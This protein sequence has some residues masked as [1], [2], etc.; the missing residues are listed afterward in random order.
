MSSDPR[1]IVIIILVIFFL[2]IPES[3]PSSVIGGDHR[4]D[5]AVAQER[6]ALKLL[7][8][9]QYGQF[10]PPNHRWLNIT[11]LQE[12]DAF[13]WDALD[14]VK[15]RAKEQAD[16]ILGREEADRALLGDTSANLPIYHNVS[17]HVRGS[18]V[19]SQ[20]ESNFKRPQ[21]NLTAFLPEDARVVRAFERNI[22]GDTGHVRFEFEEKGEMKSY[23]GTRVLDMKATVVI[24][25]ET[26]AGD[27]WSVVL[28]GH[29][30]VDAGHVILTTSSAKFPGIFALPHFALNEYL[31]KAGQEALQPRLERIINLQSSRELETINPYSSSIDD[32]S[33]NAY[34][35][36]CDLIMYLQQHPLQA[37]QKS[38]ASVSIKSSLVEDIEKELRFPDGHH[39]LA[40]PPLTMS[41]LIFSPDCGFV[42]ESKGQPD[43]P[44]SEGNHLI[45]EKQEAYIRAG[46][47]YTLLFGII[48]AGQLYLTVGQMKE[49]STP[50][51]RS[52]VSTYTIGLLSLGDG[53][54]GMAFLPLGMLIDSASP[55][56][57]STAFMAFLAVCF[58][59]MRFLLDIW[60]IQ[61]Q[62]RSRQARQHAPA[63]TTPNDRNADTPQ[64]VTTP[65]PVPI[66]TAAGV[67][68]LPL[69]I[70]SRAALASGASA[71]SLPFDQDEPTP[72]ATATQTTQ[73]NDTRR[74]LGSLYGKFYLI[75]LCIVFLSLHAT[76]WYPIL[77]SAYTNTISFIYLSFW[78]PQ[79][80]R[81]AIRNCRKALLWKFII[82][83]SV[84]RLLPIWYFYTVKENVLWAKTDSRAF[85]VLAGWVWC[86][87]WVLVVQEALGPRLFVPNSW[88]PPAYDYHPVLRED[89]EGASMPI[90]FTQAAVVDENRLSTVST[91]SMSDLQN[92]DKETKG[93]WTS[94]CAIC[95]G[96]IEAPVVPAGASE[97]EGSSF[98]GNLLARRMYM[99]TPCRHIFHTKCLESAMRYRLQCPICRESLPPL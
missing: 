64:Q 60:T 80:Y 8:R 31:F 47:S 16:H 90:G 61:V 32:S 57:L 38:G 1:A 29:H 81:N 43:Y 11:G 82:G 9:S 58:F 83:Q 6:A 96:P 70:S 88:V 94:D 34:S 63:S 50:S 17:G 48:L 75:L 68:S 23:N 18:W 84:L 66:I 53:F 69:P 72:A 49:S 99:V 73:E 30:F 2:L 19:R 15:A 37:R 42:I 79:I 85:L 51:T 78:T 12:K 20:I 4:L 22:T 97:V 25:D 5:Q 86:Q 13:A 36:Q 74:E 95:M 54:A 7:N 77:R 65:A 27:G 26:S 45:G 55:A 10:D 62:E 59:D 98:A 39:N 71:F 14:T 40:P 46:I 35:P 93:K 92:K 91:R 44:P 76:S 67:D 33:E 21:L 28:Y 24:A 3:P 89:E 52:R 87:V 56:L 41:A